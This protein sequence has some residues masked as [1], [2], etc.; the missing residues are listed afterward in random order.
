MIL[1]LSEKPYALKMLQEAFEQFAPDD[2]YCLANDERAEQAD[3]VVCW[4]P[5]NDYLMKLPHLKL[6][7][8]MGAGISHLSKEWLH[9][10][11]PVCR[12]V[13]EDH[14]QGMLEYVLWGVLYFQRDFDLA[15]QHQ[16]RGEWV[17]YPRRR[18]EDICIAVLGLG[19][20][21]GFVATQLAQMGYRVLG[22]AT[23]HK[24][25]EKVNV[26]SAKAGEKDSLYK[27]LSQADIVVNLLPLTEQTHH[28]IDA[29]FLA[30]LPDGA[31]LIQ[32]GR[33]EH[34][35]EKALL[36]VLQ[37]QRLRGAILDVFREEPL[38]IDH[39]F[40]SEERIVI[41]PH[42]ASHAS[43]E[44]VVKQVYENRRRVLSNE[45]LLNEV[46]KEKGY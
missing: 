35:D 6:I 12:V 31:A 5:P 28:I 24:E 22:F 23:A 10:A 26:F 44:T 3:T 43:L 20:L 36:E 8:S 11:Y 41:T 1:L 15:R 42:I 45:A 29:E 39:P 13:D 14:Q 7:H 21:G 27:M 4:F 34:I 18:K 17:Q 46:N 19:K 33:G 25:L 30:A 40:R 32:C 38:P 2:R 9:S 16:L 37:Q